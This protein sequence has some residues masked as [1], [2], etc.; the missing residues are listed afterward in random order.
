MLLY[1]QQ[2]VHIRLVFVWLK[3]SAWLIQ[4]PAAAV[5]GAQVSQH[6]QKHQTKKCECEARNCVNL[7]KQPRDFK[8]AGSRVILRRG[9]W[10]GWGMPL[11]VFLL[12]MAGLAKEVWAEFHITSDRFSYTI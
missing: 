7:G 5:Q 10:G 11:C 2:G 6:K 4:A 1:R 3:K 8:Q 12:L 9:G